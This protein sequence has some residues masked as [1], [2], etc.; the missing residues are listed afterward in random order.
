LKWFSRQTETF[1]TSF[2]L[3][4]Q[5]AEDRL[6]RRKRVFASAFLPLLDPDK[7]EAVLDLRCEL[8]IFEVPFSFS[9]LQTGQLESFLATFDGKVSRHSSFHVRLPR[10]PGS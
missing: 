5:I 10:A 2:V 1:S 3:C 6:N 7:M 8:G 9:L 4:L